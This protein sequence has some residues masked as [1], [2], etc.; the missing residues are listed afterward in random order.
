MYDF[1]NKYDPRNKTRIVREEGISMYDFSNKAG[2]IQA[3][4]DECE[5]QGIGLPAQVAYVLATVD[6]ETAHTFRPVSEAYWLSGPDAYLR[7]H[8]PEYYP[9]YGRGYVQLTW[10]QNYEKYGELLGKDLV[11]NPALAMDPEIALFILVHG[12]RTGAFTGKK[13]TDYIRSG[14]NDFHNARRCINGIDRVASIAAVARKYLA[15]MQK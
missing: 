7:K 6:H 14:R 13:I 11:G 1:C 9:Y 2:T 12:F 4:K 8:H 10:K 3:I 5:K 15:E